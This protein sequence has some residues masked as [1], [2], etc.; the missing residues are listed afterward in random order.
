VDITGGTFQINDSHDGQILY[1][2]HITNGRFSNAG[3]GG[4]GLILYSEVNHVP[5]GTSACA[6]IGDTLTID[7]PC[8]TNNGNPIDVG[9]LGQGPDGFWN[10]QWCS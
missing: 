2:G 8:S 3:G 5:N 7:A 6:S 9:F 10:L 1:S 4:G